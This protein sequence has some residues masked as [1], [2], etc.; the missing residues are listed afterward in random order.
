M[1]DSRAK[2]WDAFGSMSQFWVSVPHRTIIIAGMPVA[3]LFHYH[4]KSA[5]SGIKMLLLKI[6][7][8][9]V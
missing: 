6:K 9:Y 2:N 5:K 1:E 4:L 8:H 3:P 7:A